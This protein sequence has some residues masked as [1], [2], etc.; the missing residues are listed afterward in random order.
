MGR[1][2]NCEIRLKLGLPGNF[3]VFANM[4]RSFRHVWK[5]AIS[6]RNLNFNHIQRVTTHF[7]TFQTWISLS[8]THY[9]S[10]NTL[11]HV[12]RHSLPYIFLEIRV[13]LG[14]LQRVTMR[15]SHFFQV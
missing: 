7:Q 11:Q 15:Y 1:L 9:H 12:L 10:L 3:S 6:F 8:I 13:V 4:N 2:A 5:V 14:Y